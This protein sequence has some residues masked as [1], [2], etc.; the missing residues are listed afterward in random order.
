M[1]EK[2]IGE[3]GA[4]KTRRA[5]DLRILLSRSTGDSHPFAGCEN[6]GEGRQARYGVP[7]PILGPLHRRTDSGE[8]ATRV[9]GARVLLLAKGR[10]AC[11]LFGIDPRGRHSSSFVRPA[12]PSLSVASIGDLPMVRSTYGVD[13]SSYP[14]CPDPWGFP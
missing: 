5:R 12:P 8:R 4:G 2:C 14:P 3:A 7:V 9:R 13:S 1:R 6:E 11:T 10:G